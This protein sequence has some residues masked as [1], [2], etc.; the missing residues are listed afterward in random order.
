M[1]P[2]LNDISARIPDFPINPGN[3][4]AVRLYGAPQPEIFA[5]L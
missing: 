1:L 5:L 4:A 2:M 3:H